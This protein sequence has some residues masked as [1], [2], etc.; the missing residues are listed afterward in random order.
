M[1]FDNC[2]VVI[3]KSRWR[4]EIQITERDGTVHDFIAAADA[5]HAENDGIWFSTATEYEEFE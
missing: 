5:Y 1:R 4:V 3:T 2:T